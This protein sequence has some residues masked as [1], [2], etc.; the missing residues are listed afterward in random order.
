[1]YSVLHLVATATHSL[2]AI[3]WIAIVTYDLFC[4]P[5]AMVRRA[6]LVVALGTLGAFLAPVV[7]WA[8][9]AILSGSV[10]LNAAALTAFLFPLSVGYAIAR[11]GLLEG[12]DRV[13]GA[14]RAR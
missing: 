8:A 2:G 1:A 13:S 10:P 14:V 5:S 7:L 9:S 12:G 6:M 4:S 3:V 11:Q